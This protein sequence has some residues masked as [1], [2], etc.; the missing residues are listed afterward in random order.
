[1]AAARPPRPIFDN[2]TTWYLSL[3]TWLVGGLLL[4]DDWRRARRW[5]AR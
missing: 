1:M 2:R 3:V 4:F 5:G